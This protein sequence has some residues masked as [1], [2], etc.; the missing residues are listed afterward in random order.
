MYGNKQI[1]Q[2]LCIILLI[3]ILNFYRKVIKQNRDI[4]KSKVR[5]ETVL[6]APEMA[7]TIDGERVREPVLHP[8]DRSEF[9]PIDICLKEE[10]SSDQCYSNPKS[11]V[12]QLTIS[13]KTVDGHCMR[14]TNENTNYTTAYIG[15]GGCS[16]ISMENKLL[17][18]LK[19]LRIRHDMINSSSVCA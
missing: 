18:H 1:F 10:R 4:V 15:S 13:N 5:I 17:A 9:R 3:M 11:S 16:T 6:K 12:E 19:P 7:G 2:C 14:A 8:F